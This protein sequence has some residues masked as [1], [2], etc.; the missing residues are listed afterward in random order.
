MTQVIKRRSDS[1]GQIDAILAISLQLGI[2][3]GPTNPIPVPSDTDGGNTKALLFYNT[4][5]GKIQ[6]W[7]SGIWVDVTPLTDYYTAAETDAALLLKVDVSA[8]NQP[9]GYPVLN[10]SGLIGSWQLPSYVDDVVEVANLAALPTVGESGKIYVALDTNF[11][12]RWSGST[13]IRIVASPGST[14]EV[15]EGPS[16]SWLYF[17][18]ARVLASVIAAVS[19]G[20]V[21]AITATDTVLQSFGKLQA[22]ITDIYAKIGDL[23]A[24]STT[25]KTSVV[26]ALNELY[27]K[28]PTGVLV[29]NEVPGGAIDGTN[30]SFTLAFAPIDPAHLWLYVSGI[31]QEEGVGNDFTL[32]GTGFTLADAPG[33]DEK[34]TATYYK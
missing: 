10:G 17:S 9:G 18:V 2:P 29:P 12:Y 5:L 25:A 26:A 21:S 19:F 28:L 32:S 8:G 13:Y 14:D 33:T 16:G 15:P 3:T 34:M 1:V 20:T 23:T 30:A 6:V 4:T 7:L 31:L 11:E 27:S 24:L 22:Q